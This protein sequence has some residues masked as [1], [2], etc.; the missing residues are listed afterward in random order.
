MATL[1]WLG[2]WRVCPGF[3]FPGLSGLH[4]LSAARGES[5]PLNTPCTE[6]LG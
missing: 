4:Y 1:G 2:C 5:T 6:H 3:L